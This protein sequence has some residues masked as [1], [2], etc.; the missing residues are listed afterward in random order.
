MVSFAAPF[1]PLNM[2]FG[3]ALRRL[4]MH[5]P[6]PVS[7][8]WK[9]SFYGWSFFDQGRIHEKLGPAFVNVT[10]YRNVFVVADPAAIVSALTRYRQFQKIPGISRSTL[11][12]ELLQTPIKNF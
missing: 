9:Y 6:W 11:L 4:T 3:K 10:P 7:E 12:H 1:Y 5:C 8:W 2:I